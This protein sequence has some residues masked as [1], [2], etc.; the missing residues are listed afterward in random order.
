MLTKEQIG[1]IDAL[2]ELPADQVT[3][4][5]DL[6]NTE[7]VAWKSGQATELNNAANKNAMGI[8]DGVIGNVLGQFEIKDFAKTDGEKESDYLFR[9]I[10]TSVVSG[11]KTKVSDL[12]KAVA[13]SSGDETLKEELRVAKEGLEKVPGLLKTKDDEWG[14]KLK[15]EQDGNFKH[16]LS[17]DM[18]DAMPRFKQEYTD[19]PFK[20]SWLE[21]KQ[22]VAIKRIEKDW[23]ISYTD[24]GVAMAT[25]SKDGIPINTKPLAELIKSAE[26]YKDAIFKGDGQGGGGGSG[27]GEGG[28]GSGFAKLVGQEKVDAITKHLL[29]TGAKPSDT[30]WDAKYLKHFMQK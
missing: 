23:D 4:I 2:K 18:Q 30:D 25:Q 5:V 6:S 29:A 7:A 14:I 13:D 27:E 28:D 20:K 16:R 22:A 15:A 10:N 3:A 24:E 12:E 26:E 19:D 9:A 11:L 17:S 8:V 1:A 21:Q